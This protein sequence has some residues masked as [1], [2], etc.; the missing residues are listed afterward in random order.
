VLA[1]VT[2]RPAAMLAI[3]FRNL[4]MRWIKYLVSTMAGMSGEKS[5][6][7]VH[8]FCEPTNYAVRGPWLC[9]EETKAMFSAGLILANRL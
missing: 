5:A 6:C 9:L 1:V 3:S 4:R 2:E 8:L 7:R